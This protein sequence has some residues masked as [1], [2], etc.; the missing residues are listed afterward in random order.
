MSVAGRRCSF[1]RNLSLKQSFRY[2]L[3]STELLTG[4]PRLQLFCLLSGA[5]EGKVKPVEIAHHAQDF[6]LSCTSRE[7]KVNPL[8][9]LL[10]GNNFIPGTE[11]VEG[12]LTQLEQMFSCHCITFPSLLLAG[13][14]AD[15]QMSIFPLG[16]D[17]RAFISP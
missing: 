10:A 3:P 2:K 4:K 12:T 14:A 7:R 1:A 16:T 5:V 17:P 11:V 13:V 15:I 9:K 8:F 6:L